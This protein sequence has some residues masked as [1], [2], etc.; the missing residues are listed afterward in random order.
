MSSRVST[1]GR[2]ARSRRGMT[3]AAAVTLAL[4]VPTALPAVA[5]ADEGTD[6][7]I[8]NLTF[9]DATTGLTGAGARATVNGALTLDVG[10]DG[11]AARLS[12][13]NW[14]S[15]TKEDGSP[16]LAGLETVT[17]SY[18]SLPTNS[19]ANKGWTVFAA[20]NAATQTYATEKYLGVI[21]KATSLVV[22][23]YANTAGRDSTGNLN[24][25]TVAAGWRHVDLVLDGTSGTLFV[26]GTAVATNTTGKLLSAVV[27]ASGGV[28]Q[29]GKGNW[30]AGEYF[31]GLIDNLQVR[32]RAVSSDEVAVTAAAKALTLAGADA[33]AADLTLPSTASHGA[34]VTWSSSDPDVVG[35]DGT[36]TRGATAGTATLT[37]TLTVGAHT[38]TRA[39]PVTVLALA[40]TTAM[41]AALAA[42]DALVAADFTEQS[43]TPFADAVT[44]AQTVADDAAA[45]QAQVD[46]ALQALRDANLALV[47]LAGASLVADLS[48]DDATAGL[49]GAGAKATVNGEL[50]LEDGADGTQAV[51][52]SSGG[53]LNLTKD[54]GTPLLAGRDTV[55]ISYDSRPDAS[56]NVG[57]LFFA[58]PSTATQTYQ[59]EHYVGFMDK[60]TSLGV[61]RYNNAG[62][63]ISTGNLNAPAG[64]VTAGWKHVDLVLDGM[65]GALYVDGQLVASNEAGPLLS[66][67][68]GASGGVVQVGKANWVNGEYFTGLLDNLQVRGA[69]LSAAQVE[70]QL[71]QA[72]IAA[73]PATL[74]VTEDTYTLPGGPL[75]TWTS[76]SD[77][78]VVGADGRTAT[79]TRPEPGAPATTAALTA[80]VVLRGMT[81]TRAVTA[82]IS[83]PL[84]IEQRAQRTLEEISL[85]G[86]SDVRTNL[87]LP[88]EGAYDLPITWTSSHP[89]VVSE[90]GGSVAPG[91]VTRPAAA[92]TVTLTAHAGTLTRDFTA[93]VRQ[94]VAA[95]ATTDY[96]FAYFT[97]SEGSRTDEQIYFST[98]PDGKTW[99]DTRANGNPVLEWN[100][101]DKGVRDPYLVRSPQGDTFYLIATDLSIYYRGGWGSAA[102]TTTGSLKLVVWE[103]HDLVQWTEPR[104]VDVAS[105]IPGAGMAWAPEAIWDDVEQQWV[106]FW[107]TG[108]DVSNDLGDRTNMYYSTTRDFVTF[109]DPVKWIDRQHSIID[110]TMIKV[111]DWYYRASA[112]GQITI[113]RSKDLYAVT[114]AATAPAYVDDDHWSV[115]G[116]LAGILG[117]SAYSGAYLEGPEL[118]E[119]NE[120]DRVDPLTPL[121]G[122]MADQYAQGKG[123]LP[124]RTSDIGSTSAADWSL[125]SDITFGALK[126]RHGTILPITASELAALQKATLGTTGQLPVLDPQNPDAPVTYLLDQAIASAAGLVA[127]DFTAATWATFASALAT[128][129]AVAADPASQTDVDDTLAALKAARAALVVEGEGA[130]LL[131]ELTFDDATTGLSGG[132]AR[133]A[134]KG[135]LTLADGRDGT[136][137]ASLSSGNWLDV[138]KKDGTPLLKGLDEVTISYD[139]K[140]AAGS[141]NKGWSVFAAPSAATQTYQNEHYLGFIDLPTSLLV[142]R[143]DNNGTRDSSGNLAASGLADGWRHVD[144]VVKGT[145]GKLFVDGQLVASNTT[146]RALSSILGASGGVLQIGKGNWVAGEY[147]TGLIDNVR[148]Y[149]SAHRLGDEP[150]PATVTA[151]WPTLTYGTAGTVGVT[152]ASEGPT[153]TGT[154]EVRAGADVVASAT[155]DASGTAQVP[156]PATL[157]VGS[158][159]LVVAYLGDDDTEPATA[160]AQTVEVG[161]ASSSTAVSAGTVRHG[162]GGTVTVR[163]TSVPGATVLPTGT[164]R[165]TDA[166]DSSVRTATLSGGTATFA[167]PKSVAPG[168]HRF[169]AQYLG[170]G[171]VAASAAALTVKVL[172]ATSATTA[173]V[174]TVRYGSG[175]TVSVTVTSAV[176]SKA[177]AG[178]VRV[179]NV[180]GG[181]VRYG[182]V[183]NG[184]AV[185]SLPTTLKPGT[186]RFTVAYLGTTTIEPSS[187]TVTV[188]VGR[189]VSTTTVAAARV[190]TGIKAT[191]A[192]TAK[193]VT[194]VAGKVKVAVLKNGKTVSTRTVSLV[195]G[196]YSVVL[197]VRAKGSYQVRAT[198]QST[199]TVLSSTATRALKIG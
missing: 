41:D 78:V 99:T 152:V 157:A 147:F 191:G 173:K 58:A 4:A 37:A 143:Y 1:N 126:T 16:L 52:L 155:L 122:L 30:E 197:P 20:P 108:S 116:T 82:T 2:T 184:K 7:L 103:S 27:G 88:T 101:G 44:A 42:A 109:T 178:R 89:A 28:F 176:G 105:G 189:A 180:A 110:T 135:T 113:E 65:Q 86:L 119:Y 18:D 188:K 40:D 50:T 166:F 183:T 179:S 174:S 104:L 132:V 76:A 95:P 25:G 154:V 14:L 161:K 92:T 124:F 182:T 66:A 64:T 168:S 199:T 47:S 73:I 57:W 90:S 59:N 192:V 3:V 67:I 61:E 138:T 162:T 117:T 185:V 133:A 62:A 121:Y 68:L 163:V 75:V 128:A 80:G 181:S 175:G 118:F 53:W 198:F 39:F 13:G 127:A 33:V 22:E 145:S 158:H 31:A 177:T 60:A 56:G 96:V 46:A 74:A 194:P 98:S 172:R 186:Y 196:R 140:P 144:L 34:T 123:Y 165:L 112:D 32:S 48:F 12:V 167:L 8:A 170:S 21:D 15:L 102:A 71:A 5:S 115:V 11:K 45:T 156:L 72:A 164:V 136:K 111:G 91:V 114:T 141:A 153:P 171:E 142:E 43:W 70:A 69:A 26:D 10:V 137:A 29:I 169:S 85:V 107:A 195:K 17:I 150:F 134:V 94:A 24:A 149:A 38:A 125:A 139:S 131:A 35:D 190:S 54:D 63:R 49:T 79:V 84:T 130:D 106:V 87:T 51:R 148:I 93:E 9:D 187:R 100:A 83:A 81:V 19:S 129:Q 6:A 146:G 97:G 36:V 77:D 151:T 23:R 55:T 120:D 159:T 160:A 193:G